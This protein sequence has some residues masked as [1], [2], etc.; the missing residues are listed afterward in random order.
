MRNELNRI[1]NELEHKKRE[2]A[3]F[4]SQM[5]LTRNRLRVAY[6]RRF[7]QVR[8]ERDRLERRLAHM[9]LGVSPD[10]PLPGPSSP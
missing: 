7:L 9:E 4:E 1:R 8:R 5:R 6:A 10:R 2:S 3:Y